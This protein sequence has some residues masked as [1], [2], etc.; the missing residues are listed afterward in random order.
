M[1]SDTILDGG[2]FRYR[3]VPDWARLPDGWDFHEKLIKVA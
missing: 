2:E 1:N 3:L